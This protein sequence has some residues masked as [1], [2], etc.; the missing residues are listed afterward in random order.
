M[1]GIPKKPVYQ[2]QNE[3][4]VRVWES[5]Y[6]ASKHGYNATSIRDVCIGR[7]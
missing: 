2:L 4:V 3:T 7:R 1:R 5:A 6:E